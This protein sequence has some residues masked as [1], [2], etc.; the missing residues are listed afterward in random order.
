MTSL[1]QE[2]TGKDQYKFGDI[3]KVIMAQAKEKN[4]TPRTLPLNKI[5]DG[6]EEWDAQHTRDATAQK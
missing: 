5:V 6:I 1:V 2:F 3:A 4:S